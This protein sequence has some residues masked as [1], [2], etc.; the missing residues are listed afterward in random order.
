MCNGPKR[1]RFLFKFQ[2]DVVRFHHLAHMKQ[3]ICRRG[4]SR[5]WKALVEEMKHAWLAA[6]QVFGHQTRQNDRSV[7]SVWSERD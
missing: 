2:I 5:A 4:A 7:R 1:I 3:Y 6:L